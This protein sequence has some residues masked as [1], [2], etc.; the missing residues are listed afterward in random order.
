MYIP[1]P[2][3]WHLMSK[4]GK[5]LWELTDGKE[6]AEELQ[7]RAE[8]SQKLRTEIEDGTLKGEELPF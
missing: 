2:A 8:L 4:E 7:A 3:N 6:K 5:K 1:K